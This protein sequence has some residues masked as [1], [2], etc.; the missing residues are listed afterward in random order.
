MPTGWILLTLCLTG[1]WTP[2]A[3]PEELRVGAAASLQDALREIAAAY[4]KQSGTKVLLHFGSSG[5]IMSQVRNGAPVDVFISAADRQ[6]DEL[7]KDGLVVRD[8]RRVIA[9]NKLVLVVPPDAR[10]APKDFN[11]LAS[12]G[13][14][15]LAIGEP[16][17]VPAG[18]YATQVLEKAGVADSLRG[19]LVYGANVRQVLG[20]VERGEVTAGIVYATDA[21]AA[22][23]KVR[24]VAV[25]DAAWHDPVVYPAVVVTASKRGESAGRFLDYLSSD[26]AKAVL[27]GKGFTAGEAKARDAGPAIVPGAGAP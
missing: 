1:F 16:K 6:V 12:P 21:A 4:E 18:Q 27:D 26:A 13:V 14:K 24:V 15:R 9:G 17:T 11:S 5:Q 8:S 3:S 19:R 25:S 23:D 20:Y 10:D 7:E 2:Q 22:G